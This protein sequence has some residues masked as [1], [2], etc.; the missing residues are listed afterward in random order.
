M[1]TVEIICLWCKGKFIK[2]SRGKT[3]AKTCSKSCASYE[4]QNRPEVKAKIAATIEK[5]RVVRPNKR[6]L[7]CK[8]WFYPKSSKIQRFCGHSCSAKWRM[9]L[10]EFKEMA[11]R[12]AKAAQLARTG[13][14]DPAA[15]L[16][17]RLRNPVWMP[18]VIERISK[19]KKGQ[20]FLSRGGNGQLTKPQKYLLNLLGWSLK[21]AEL[22]I[23][24]LSVREKFKS[25]PTCYK[26][27]LGHRETKT[28]IEVD[29]GSHKSKFWR[30]IDK[31]KTEVLNELGW[32]VLRFWNEEV[33]SSG[34]EVAR[35]I[36]AT[37]KERARSTRVTTRV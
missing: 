19:A 5:N 25:L 28:A 34:N 33:L 2:R 35:N 11:K 10:P 29:G 14:K 16:R 17:M 15:S 32:I 1:K 27:D 22:P 9:S 20:T 18:G 24:T 31:R 26:V 4:S 36:R 6:C 13:K 7:I 12:A 21:R 30:F 3:T 37:I 8:R 23:R